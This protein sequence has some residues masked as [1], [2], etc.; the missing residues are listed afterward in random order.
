MH[1]FNKVNWIF[2]PLFLYS[3]CLCTTICIVILNLYL[4]VVLLKIIL[5]KD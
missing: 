1:N 2:L 3:V 5:M 4:D